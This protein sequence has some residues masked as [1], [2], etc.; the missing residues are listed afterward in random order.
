MSKAAFEKISKD[1]QEMVLLQ[2]QAN[3]EGIKKL[4]AEMKEF[5][6]ANV[7]QTKENHRV[8]DALAIASRSPNADEEI[9]KIIA[10]I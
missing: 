1:M 9:A 2:I 5:Y 7:E 8:I 6:I 10:A 4:Q 3:K